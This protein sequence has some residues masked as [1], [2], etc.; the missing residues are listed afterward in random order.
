[1]TFDPVTTDPATFD[2]GDPDAARAARRALRAARARATGRADRFMDAYVTVFSV[3]LISVWILSFGQRSFVGAGCGGCVPTQAPVL[4]ALAWGL[5]LGGVLLLVLGA[6]GPVSA[7]RADARWLLG[8]TAD[9]AILLRAPLVAATVLAAAGGTVAGLM[10]TLAATG[11]AVDPVAL[12]AGAALGAAL[13]AAAPAALLPG[14]ARLG[15]GLAGRGTGVAFL[16][17]GLALLLAA[18]FTEGPGLHRGLGLTL[19][20]GGAGVVVVVGS[21]L[22]W[23]AP[24]HLVTLD[25]R[26]LAAG[27]EVV[28]AVAGSVTMMDPHLTDGLLQRRRAQHRGTFHS[29]QGRGHGAWAFLDADLTMSARR[30]RGL[31]VHLAWI[32]VTLVVAQGMGYGAGVVMTGVTAAWAARSAGA[33]LRSWLASPGLRRWVTAPHLAVTAALTVMPVLVSSAV[34]LPTLLLLDAPAWAALH[35]ALAGLA[36]T[37]RAADP[38]SPDLGAVVTTPMGALPVG[39]AQAVLHGPDVALALA[40]VLVVWPHPGVLLLALAAL[41]WQVSR[42]RS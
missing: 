12:A 36:A 29:R 2:S 7:G 26:R 15:V 1:M 37:M 21:W 9:R 6:V 5:S 34:S 20:F 27:R 10:V 38:A 35:V 24:R 8:T 28:D 11:G 32:P 4:T 30:A 17:V 3:A 18:Q 39:L 31:V 25:D 14:Q 13:G 33:G 41:A 16:S 22:A 40:I 23:R 19:A 42:D